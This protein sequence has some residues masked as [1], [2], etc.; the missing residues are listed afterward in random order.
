MLYFTFLNICKT[1]IIFGD[2]PIWGKTSIQEC[3]YMQRTKIHLLYTDEGQQ[4][5]KYTK[6]YQKKFN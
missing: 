4:Q 5:H 3:L 6:S 2:P 1:E